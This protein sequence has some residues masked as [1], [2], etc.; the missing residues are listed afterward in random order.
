MHDS[1]ADDLLQ[2]L[3]RIA[4][5]AVAHRTVQSM[6][7]ALVILARELIPTAD[8]V[9]I[10]LRADREWTTTSR[11]DDFVDEID[12]RQYQAKAGP[13]LSAA[14]EQRIYRSNDLAAD[15]R[16]PQFARQAAAAG[17][18]SVVSAPLR[19]GQGVTG[20]LN[21]YGLAP[22]AFTAV[23]DELATVL[24]RHATI[25]IANRSAIGDAETLTDQLRDALKSRE[26]I[27]EAKGILMHRESLTSDEAFDVLREMSQ[28][29]NRKLRTIAEEIV[30]G[31]RNR[32]NKQ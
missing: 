28:S 25:A 14:T 23:T 11:S 30:D 7:D 21:I 4:G 1:E 12:A 3:E 24:A 2:A 6:L 22:S 16:W 29:Q 32:G 17:V 19:A 9:G 26:V 31:V 18:R 8:G 20:A 27:G 10:T 13:C 5:L 15:D